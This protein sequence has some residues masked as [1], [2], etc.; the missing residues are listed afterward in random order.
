MNTSYGHPDMDIELD[1]CVDKDETVCV[2][3][4]KPFVKELSWIEYD[5]QNA[6]IDFVM[7]D[8][9]IRNYGMPV[10]PSVQ[11]YMHGKSS[12]AFVKREGRELLDEMEIPLIVRE[13]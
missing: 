5:I 3:Y 1:M 2:L 10:P 12:I 11:P 4:D 13:H 8:G 9:D 6:S 7:D